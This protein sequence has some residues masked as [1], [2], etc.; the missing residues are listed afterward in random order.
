MDEELWI[1]PRDVALPV[2]EVGDVPAVAVMAFVGKTVPSDT[3]TTSRCES[4]K[5]PQ[6]HVVAHISGVAV[7]HPDQPAVFST[8][9][10]TEG[11]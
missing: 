7:L 3:E 1:E 10:W 6:L 5:Q 2:I 11:S 9:F 4:P 8:I